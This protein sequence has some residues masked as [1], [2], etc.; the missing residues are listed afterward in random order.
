MPA[1]LVLLSPTPLLFKHAYWLSAAARWMLAGLWPLNQ[2]ACWP[3]VTRYCMSAGVV[4]LYL[5]YLL[6]WCLTISRACWHDIS[7]SAIPTGV[8]LNYR[9]CLLVWYLTISHACW[10]GVSLW[11]MPSGVV[12]HCRSYLLVWCLTIGH[13]CW[14]GTSLKALPA[15]PFCTSTNILTSWVQR[16]VGWLQALCYSYRGAITS[17]MSADP[18]PLLDMPACTVQ[19]YQTRMLGSFIQI[20]VLVK[21][22]SIIQDIWYVTNPPDMPTGK[23]WLPRVCYQSGRHLEYIKFWVMHQ[24][25]HWDVTRMMSE[26]PMHAHPWSLS[27]SGNVILYSCNKLPFWRP[28]CLHSYF[29]Y[30][31]VR[32]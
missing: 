1:G 20:N 21:C 18:V 22:I 25:H 17:D 5:L 8:V 14:R 7:L 31:F 23:V 16:E 12:P 26:T 11:A 27:T 9:S 32:S 4:L 24:L 29:F 30:I 10:C 19:L 28:F 3:F 15:G 6:L 13:V 2:H